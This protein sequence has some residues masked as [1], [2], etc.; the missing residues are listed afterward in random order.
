ALDD[1]PAFI[2]KS[3]LSLASGPADRIA[4]TADRERIRAD[5]PVARLHVSARD[6]VGNPAA[7]ALEFESS[8]GELRP[9]A[10][11]AGEWDLHLAMPASFDGLKTVEVRAL[12]AN[13]SSV[14]AFA[15]EAGPLETLAFEE[16]N[17][18]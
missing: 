11:A 4:I 5:Q 6:A 10:T 1:A 16:P 17:A 9:T 12:A 13:A 18:V 3:V 7:D 2:A 8:A 14:H 15:L